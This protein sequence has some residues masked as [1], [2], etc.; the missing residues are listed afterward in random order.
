MQ[1]RVGLKF[2]L[3]IAVPLLLASLGVFYLTT[4]L[5]GRVSTG[6]N[7]EDHERTKQVVESAFK[8]SQQQLANITTDNSFWDDAVR[9]IYGTP[10][11]EW[12]TTSWGDASESGINYDMAFVVDRSQSETLV[13]F[14]SGKEFKANIGTYFTGKLDALLDQLKTQP[15]NH[16]AKSSIM[17]TRDGLAIVAAAP[18]LPTSTDILIPQASPRFLVMVKIMSPEHLSALETQYVIEDLRIKPAAVAADLILTDQSG[19]MT[20]AVMWKDRKPGDIV[21]SSVISKALLILSFLGLAVGLVALRCWSLLGMTIAGENKARYEA[22]HDLLTGLPNRAALHVEIDRIVKLE[23][24]SVAIAFAD[25]DGFKEVNDSYGH[26][27]GDQLIIEVAKEFQKIAGES[28]IVC[29]LGGDEFVFVLHGANAESRAC[30]LASETIRFLG[31]AFDL[32][33]RMACVG[34]SIGIA[35][36]INTNAKADELMR[37]ADIAMYKAKENGKN[38]YVVFNAEFDVARNEEIEITTELREILK[39]DLLEVAYQPIVDAQSRKIVAVEA[40][41]RWPASSTRRLTP[42]RFIA[43]AERQG[44]INDLGDIILAKACAAASHWPE[45]RVSINISTV[46]LQ[47]PNFVTRTLKTIKESGIAYSRVELEITEGTLVSDIEVAQRIF[48]ELRAT[49]IQIALD[50]FGTGFS[51]IGYLRQFSF[52]RIK[53]DRSLINKVLLGS[54]EQQIVQGT[55]LMANGLAATVT[56]EGVELE[57]QV[58]ILRLSGCN[59]MQGYYFFRPMPAAELSRI[60]AKLS[61]DHRLALSA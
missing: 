48:D 59:E 50:D 18:I 23:S 1:K 49:G 46:Q 60:L 53:I 14:Q 22:L 31:T 32:N 11:L 42:D 43:I 5:I 34:A 2:V 45:L 30:D 40:L 3:T 10:N 7:Q 24:N 44:L 26:D 39:S 36:S 56:A 19:E 29:R 28:G 8:A 41:A 51:S 35:S 13:G 25:L 47:N 17:Q 37:R 54:S 6:A 21:K 38:R 61:F 33:G 27:V 9:N 55:M 16:E 15:S 58:D 52:D 12:A 57:D 4:D 20:A